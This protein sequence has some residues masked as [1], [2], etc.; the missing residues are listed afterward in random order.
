VTMVTICSRGT[1][2]GDSKSASGDPQELS[3]QYQDVQQNYEEVGGLPEGATLDVFEVAGSIK[4]FD[5]SKGF[6]FIVP[7]NG[8]GDILLHITCLRAGGYQ[9]AYEGA[10][11]HCQVLRRP[12]GL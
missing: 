9:T 1:T 8:L 4:W 11:V 7:D 3:Q 10:R 12:K 5:A 6:G 2:M